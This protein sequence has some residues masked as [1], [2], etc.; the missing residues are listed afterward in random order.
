MNLIPLEEISIDIQSL[1]NQSSEISQWIDIRHKLTAN[2]QFN[3]YG[4]GDKEEGRKALKLRNVLDESIFRITPKDMMR[5]DMAGVPAMIRAINL[6]N[7]SEKMALL[8]GIVR[9]AKITSTKQE[10]VS[11]I[12]DPDKLERFSHAHQQLLKDGATGLKFFA[13]R[14]LNKVIDALQEEGRLLI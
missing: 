8:E 6:E 11:F 14:K 9:E 13:N 7:L 1:K 4:A 12:M 2:I 5:G 10:L 3:L